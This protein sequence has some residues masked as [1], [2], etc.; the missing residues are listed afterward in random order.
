[1]L[2]GHSQGGIAAMNLAADPHWHVTD[3]VTAGSPVGNK[4]VPPG[5][6]V[7]RVENRGDPVPLLDGDREPGA[8]LFGPPPRLSHLLSSHDLGSGYLAELGSARFAA[9]P[10]ARG[11]TAGA[12]PYLSAGYGTPR[13]FRLDAGRYGAPAVLVGLSGSGAGS[14]GGG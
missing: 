12:A 9:D 5:T 2:V 4:R 1:M 10:L 13:R 3:I 7:L 14:D 6:R 8:Y 11:F